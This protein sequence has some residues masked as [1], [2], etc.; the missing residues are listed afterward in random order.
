GA[1]ALRRSWFFPIFAML[2]PAATV[3]VTG[4]IWGVRP[5]GWTILPAPIVAAPCMLGYGFVLTPI[6]LGIL[7]VL[8]FRDSAKAIGRSGALRACS[9]A[10]LAGFILCGALYAHVARSDRLGRELI[11]AVERND[12][13]RVAHLIY[14][15]A[16][17]NAPDGQGQ[18]AVMAAIRKDRPA[19]LKYL[20]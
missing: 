18:T 1:E 8:T 9:V 16:N 14:E 10:G 13:P 3:L 19:L 11:A 12:L 20:L 15:G 5:S 7:L 2:A 4:Y 17:P 6:A